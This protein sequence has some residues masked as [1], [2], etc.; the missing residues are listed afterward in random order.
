MHDDCPLEAS[1]LITCLLPSLQPS[2]LHSKANVSTADAR[3]AH[4]SRNPLTFAGGLDM[5]PPM[6]ELE[7]KQT[8][9]DLTHIWPC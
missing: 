3:A 7:S 6:L 1:V 4:L 8:I 5:S 9:Y 2:E